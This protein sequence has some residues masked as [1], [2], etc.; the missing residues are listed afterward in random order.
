MYME[1]GRKIPQ[2][3]GPGHSAPGTGHRA[4][5]YPNRPSNPT[6]PASPDIPATVMAP[7]HLG[8]RPLSSP[9]VSSPR[10]PQGSSNRQ[11]GPHPSHRD[12][13]AFQNDPSPLQ[14]DPAP[15]QRDSTAFQPDPAPFPRRGTNHRTFLTA[16]RSAV[17]K[18]AAHKDTLIK[19]GMPDGLV[20][21][22][23]T[24]LDQ[25][26]HAADDKSAAR[27]AHVGAS[28]DLMA[29]TE[30]IM[31]LIQQLDALNRYRFRKDSELL[32]AWK[33]VRDIEWPHPGNPE[34]VSG[35]TTGPT[36]VV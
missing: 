19:Y 31:Q 27:S 9:G 35:T 36:P 24:A 12:P 32:A 11:R 23:T 13:A 4:R 30:E 1:E 25:Y 14:R 20:E 7:V 15:L 29:I 8:G 18:A 17:E 5:P 6:P 10:R 3:M 34:P 28:A 2:P 26:E 22:I 16:A 21:E 33:S